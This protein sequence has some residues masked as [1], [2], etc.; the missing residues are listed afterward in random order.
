MKK[1]LG[2]LLAMTM[3]WPV[4]ASAEVLKN[5]DLKGE[6][7]TIAS[8]ARHDKNKAYQSGTNFRVLAGL[9]ADLVEDVRA[10]V[11]FQYNAAWFSGTDGNTVQ[12][13]WD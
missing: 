9:S 2:L 10:N 5:V 6:I 13:Y 8:D 3:A 7:Q 4:T 12:N 11:L 1:L